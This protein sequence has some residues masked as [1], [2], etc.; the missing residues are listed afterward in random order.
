LVPILGN[1]FMVSNRR[2]GIAH[3]QE[4]LLWSFRLFG[5][6]K[7]DDLFLWVLLMLVPYLVPLPAYLLLTF[8]CTSSDIRIMILGLNVY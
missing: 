4:Y 1:H 8:L 2:I 3:P 6:I 7:G 5:N